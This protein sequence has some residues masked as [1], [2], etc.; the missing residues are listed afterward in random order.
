MMRKIKCWLKSL[1]TIE[2]EIKEKLSDRIIKENKI[3]YHLK[4]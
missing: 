2:E 1:I 4:F 3:K